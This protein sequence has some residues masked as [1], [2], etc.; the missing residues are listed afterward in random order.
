M[1]ERIQG[2]INAIYKLKKSN[3]DGKNVSLSS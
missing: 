1:V 2:A 3:L